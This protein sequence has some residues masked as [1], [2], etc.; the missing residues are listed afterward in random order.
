M[1]FDFNE[2]NLQKLEIKCR[3]FLGQVKARDK[4][5][6]NELVDTFNN[7]EVNELPNWYRQALEKYNALPPIKK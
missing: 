3:Y 5:L 1:D 7:A 6:W 2:G 4:K